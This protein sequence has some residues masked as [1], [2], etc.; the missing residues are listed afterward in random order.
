M[1]ET[2]TRTADDPNWEEIRPVLDGAMHELGARDREAILLRYF[3]NRPYAEI[4]AA[5]GLNENAARMR[6]ERALDRLRDR[7]VRRGV[8]SS[9]AALGLVLSTQTVMAAPAGLA[10]TAAS[11]SLAGLGSAGV[12]LNLITFMSM[13]KAKLGAIGAITAVL[14][15]G[16]GGY[17]VGQSTERANSATAGRGSEMQA[18]ELLK[19]R[20]QLAE[21]EAT[22][23]RLARER[24]ALQDENERL[25]REPPEATALAQGSQTTADGLDQL[26]MWLD[27]Q[28]RRLVNGRLTLVENSGKLS[29]AF[30]ELFKLTPAERDNLQQEL[31]RARQR[32]DGVLLASAT[33]SRR[34][35]DNVVIEIPPMTGGEG[36]YDRLFD[37]FAQTLG[38]ERNALFVELGTQQVEQAFNQF[39]AEKR[40]ITLTRT[41]AEPGG[42]PAF[43]VRDER[44]MTF[45][46]V[47]DSSTIERTKLGDTLGA[48]TRL[49]PADF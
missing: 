17:V 38:P 19:L 39:G 6:V 9:A 11:V 32:L 44:K 42:N 1:N 28:K 7:L 15:A 36:L 48:I 2:E 31:D 3:E 24:V 21:T 20:G 27:L 41:V 30:I 5:C 13:T 29:A 34:D 16:A 8:T 47:T 22:S 26:R 10:A 12:G 14:A 35:A 18:E 37:A 49:V 43:I 45:G 23:A 46:A 25:K 33:V 40:T 4:A